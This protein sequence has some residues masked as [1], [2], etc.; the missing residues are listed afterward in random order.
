MYDGPHKTEQDVDRVTSCPRE[1]PWRPR[2]LHAGLPQSFGS[3]LERIFLYM[4]IFTCTCLCIFFWTPTLMRVRKARENRHVWRLSMK[5]L[6]SQGKKGA[7]E[8]VRA[9]GPGSWARHAE[10]HRIKQPAAGGK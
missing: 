3:F 6:G 8:E 10:T 1:S 2:G 5:L 9:A 4:H 7:P